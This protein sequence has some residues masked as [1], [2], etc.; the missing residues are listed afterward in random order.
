MA[1]VTTSTEH[2]LMPNIMAVVM[3]FHVFILMRWWWPSIQQRLAH[4]CNGNFCNYFIFCSHLRLELIGQ[5]CYSC[6][7]FC[8]NKFWNL[9]WKQR[10]DV[11]VSL[12]WR[13]GIFDQQKNGS[14]LRALVNAPGSGLNRGD[15]NEGSTSAVKV[16]SGFTGR[17]SNTSKP[18]S[19]AR[20][21][22]T[23]KIAKKNHTLQ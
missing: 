3:L 20:G 1:L 2:A 8:I 16:S 9:L 22:G 14:I 13:S 10:F 15:K 11:R 6:P 12:L 21:T 5:V 18:L 23:S 7:L 4:G 19:G 17:S